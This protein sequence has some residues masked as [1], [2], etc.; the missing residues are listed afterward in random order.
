MDPRGE[1]IALPGEHTTRAD[2]RPARHLDRRGLPRGGDCSAATPSSIRPTVLTT[3]L[4]E[5]LKDNMAE[6]LSYAEMQKLLDDLPARSSRSSS[7]TSIPAQISVGGIQRVLQT[8]LRER[9]SIRDLPTILEG[10]A[11]AAA[12]PATSSAD[13]RA[14]PRAPRAASSARRHRRRRR[15]ADRHPVAGLGAGLRR[16]RWSA[17]ARRSS[18]RW[19]RRSCRSSSPSVRETFERA[20]MMGETPVLL[21]SPR[22]PALCPLDHRTLP[23]ADRHVAER[24][25]LQ[26]THQ[27]CRPSLERKRRCMG[28]LQFC[29]RCNGTAR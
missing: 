27:D 29:C 14:C 16:S 20:A 11:E 7:T 8:L 10:I 3:H 28:T 24:G 6:L 15:P 18:S 25:L 5:I 9:I 22:R 2:L 26:S 23:P 19:R 4:T 13:R 12:T 17:R 21:T 1:A